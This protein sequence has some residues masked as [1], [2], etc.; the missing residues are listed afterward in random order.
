MH[1]VSRYEI[2]K[3]Q[4]SAALF[5]LGCYCLF[6]VLL[7]ACCCAWPL[8]AAALLLSCCGPRHAGV[9]YCPLPL[10]TCWKCRRVR[11][12]GL[13]QRWQRASWPAAKPRMHGPRP[14]AGA[15]PHCRHAPGAVAAA[16]AD[17]GCGVRVWLVAAAE[18]QQGPAGHM[19]MHMHVKTGM[20]MRPGQGPA[21]SCIYC[22]RLAL[23]P[24]TAT[25]RPGQQAVQVAG[26]HHKAPPDLP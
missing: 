24:S 16:L 21:W 13:G 6:V 12:F 2:S 1:R 9:L 8:A 17:T 19:C 7:A 22:K 18:Y 4:T 15:T 25:G 11:R 20:H 26:V 23:L 14:A 5:S 10:G 3:R